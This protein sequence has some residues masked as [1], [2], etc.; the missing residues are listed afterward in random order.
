[1]I[2]SIKM[3]VTQLSDFPGDSVGKNLPE[4]EETG[5]LIL[6]WEDVQERE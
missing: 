6:G 1:M 3:R 2:L 4:M 5:V